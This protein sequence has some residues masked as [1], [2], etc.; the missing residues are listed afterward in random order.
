MN[1]SD[2]DKQFSEI[3]M[4][5]KE[6]NISYN[7]IDEKD[8][9]E[10]IGRLPLDK[11]FTKLA[12]LYLAADDNQ[13]NSLYAY[14]GQ[15]K[16]ILEN[17]WVFVRRLG[18][19][20]H[21]EENME[22]LEVALSSAMLDGGRGEFRELIGSLVVVRFIAEGVG[23]DIRSA[24][25]PFIQSASADMKGLLE[26]VRDH[27]DEDVHFI[28]QTMAPPEWALRSIRIFGVNDLQTIVKAARE[29]DK[30]R[31]AAWQKKH[32]VLKMLG[33]LLKGK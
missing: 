2:F 9:W 21:S 14:C 33:D 6:R 28:V 26:N 10:N 27:P 31:E 24:F 1:Q 7:F 25:E 13:K 20:I 11:T 8:I 29:T 22:W 32:P 23:I 3:Q 15:Q 30:Q 4:A 19:L 5:L 12:R 16:I 18:R 17:L